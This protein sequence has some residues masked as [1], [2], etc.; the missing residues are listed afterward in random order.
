MFGDV[1]GVSLLSSCTF[2]FRKKAGARWERASLRLAP[3]SAYLLRGPARTDWEHSIPGVQ[4]LRYSL[5]FRT[6]RSRSRPQ[7]SN[8]RSQS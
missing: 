5:T 7:A 6:L 2:R 1:L 8:P 4:E 3:R